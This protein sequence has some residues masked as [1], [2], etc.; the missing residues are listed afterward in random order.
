MRLSTV[1]LLAPLLAAQTTVYLRTPGVPGFVINGASNATPAVVQ[2]VAT[3][4][5]SAGDTVTLWGLGASVSGNCVSSS[6]NGLRKVKAVVDVTHFSVT[7]LSGTD[8]PAN[9][10]WCDGSAPGNP[11]GAMAGGKV[12]AY[13]PVA[14]PRGWL[15]GP[16]GT[17]MRRL[18]LGT[19]NGLVSLVVSGN[20]AT[21]TTSYAHGINIGDKVGVWGSGNASL[22]NSGNPYT[23]TAATATTFSFTTSGVSNGTYTNS[24]NTCGPG[25]TADCLRIS[26]VAWT[27]SIFWDAAVNRDL[28]GWETGS[29]YKH[30]FDG[31]NLY[32]GNSMAS[33]WALAGLKAFVDPSDA[34]MITIA[35]Y[36]VNHVE[37]QSGVS[38]TSVEPTS[39]GG[40]N[41]LND[42]GS[43]AV[44]GA[45]LCYM[46]ARD[47][48][49]SAEKQA[50][51]DKMYNDIDY[52]N[53][54]ACNKTRT[55]PQAKT[56]ASGT[57]QAGS[58]TTITLAGSD[59]A[60]D[61]FYVNN[62]I[63]AM[64]SG[65][66]SFGLVTGYAGG[67]KV[68]TVGSWSNGT[69]TAGTAYSIYATATITSTAA[70][71]TTTITGVNTHFTTDFQV[72]DAIIA[73]NYPWAST[74]YIEASESYISAINSDTSMT[75]INSLTPLS[76]STTPA[77][78][79]ALHQWQ[80][81]DCG[82]RWA[83]NHWVGAM[84]ALPSLYFGG[85]TSTG[86]SSQPNP[87]TPVLGGN[88]GYTRSAAWT[89]LGFVLADDDTRAIVSLAE[90]ESQ[91][92]DWHQRLSWNYSTGIEHSGANYSFDRVQMDGFRGVWV[93]AN[94]VPA[95]AG[96]MDL[97]G[98]WVSQ[99]P[100][101]KMY[102]TY[103]D[104]RWNGDKFSPWPT[105]WGSAVGINVVSG[106]SGP[107]TTWQNMAAF[108]WMPND[109]RT[110][111]FWSFATAF[112]CVETWPYIWD[113]RAYMGLVSFDPR[114]QGSDYTVQPN[115]YAF[116]QTSAAT[117]CANTGWACPATMRADAVVSHTG[118][119]SA[120]SPNLNA[121]QV[122]FGGRTFV[123]DHDVP[124]MGTLRVYK[125]GHL[126][127]SD[128]SPPGSSN[129]ADDTTTTDT[130]P[131]IGGLTTV[132]ATYRGLNNGNGP[133]IAYISRWAS[134]GHG[135]WDSSYGDANSRYAYA[136]VDMTQSYKTLYNRVQRH[137]VHFKNPGTE[138]IIVQFDDIDISNAPNQ[139]EMHIHYP[140]N[141]EANIDGYNEGNT[142]CP[143]VG[144]CAAL[145][146]TRLIQSL[147][148][149]GSDGHSP[150]RNYGIVSR[151]F[152][153][154]RIFV[155]DDGS[156]YAGAG[157]HTHR[158]SLCGG[159]S[160][161]AVVNSFEAMIVHKIAAGL[162]DT[163]LTA[164]LLS[165]D[166]NWANVETTDAG[167]AAGKVAMIAR[168]GLTPFSANVQTDHS[169]MG[170]YLIAGLQPGFLY[171]VYR[172]DDNTDVTAQEVSDGDNSLYFE[173]PAGS[174]SV[175]PEGL[176]KLF[177]RPGIPRA[178]AGLS[179]EYD[180]PPPGSAPDFEWQIG[181]GQ[182]PA[183]L[184]LSAAGILSGT[185]STSGSF[186]FT[187]TARAI[188][189]PSVSKSLSMT[190]Q[191]APPALNLGLKV[192]TSSRAVLTYGL[193]GLDALQRCTLTVSDQPDFNT[194]IESFTD[195]G[196]AAVRW[197]AVGA[198]AAL[199]PAQTYYVQADCGPSIANS[200][201]SFATAPAVVR[202]PATVRVSGMRHPGD[203]TA[204]MQV[205]YGSTPELGSVV[206]VPCT[207]ACTADLP[208]MT[209]TLL[210][211][212][213]LY[214]DSASR[215][216]AASSIAP[217]GVLP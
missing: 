158:V 209:D 143:G 184:T 204:A 13:S 60:G 46:G 4:G 149:G 18:S 122:Y 163:V 10:P 211:T 140:Q 65:N 83:Q 215:V 115:Q 96:G 108:A 147:E 169:G 216:L 177:V 21:A 154:G 173:A 114:I 193:R 171:R 150:A 57:A 217:A 36:C 32:G 14:Q 99:V 131:R 31:G 130:L 24:N 53:A 178:Q 75:V 205:Q 202:R 93:I 58:S 162:S 67:T 38:W 208:A 175:F 61:G 15:D 17:A 76:S 7:D 156:S 77:T 69:P 139:V 181:S 165:P 94:S 117:A 119:G 189:Y 39:Q 101:M 68:A 45:S 188:K 84:G 120:G 198:A 72:G 141:G 59:S 133:A 19:N 194:T 191:V 34:Q 113:Q 167:G 62:V 50:F 109:Y 183:G 81:G 155:R 78:V 88:N 196:G 54:S 43:Y 136:M 206:T 97:T 170:Q 22:K 9:G 160:C 172:Y 70:G 64:V 197:Y 144:G 28:A 56:L 55:M 159:S 6:V 89:A 212:R 174:Y 180:F 127:N 123:G 110:K 176:R 3:H 166:P 5:L 124:E 29:T 63:E 148:D 27:G 40:N 48:L 203:G 79:W 80:T 33:N 2:T 164:K 132:N 42:F 146:S 66:R 135:T 52:L 73:R 105:R 153:P 179:F 161:G 25:G 152:S 16:T 200:S 103:P 214:L 87:Q 134:A 168:N 125:V 92:W 106:P 47:Y 12:T 86:S 192:V 126:L 26:Q 116:R 37:R 182:L 104:H 111:Y 121:T 41:D 201:I 23:I 138:E 90:T 128:S 112:C 195:G 44:T 213:R 74:L 187:V 11:G 71:V 137:M 82:I 8:V 49:T 207:G 35:K 30:K 157:G 129:E 20:Q 145:D 91:F 210:F 1:L 51:A 100:M 142:T 98:P 102:A 151:M 185:P 190:L 95:L 118:W 85:G 186:T 107:A 199:V